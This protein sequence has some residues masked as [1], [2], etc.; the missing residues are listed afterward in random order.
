M[1]RVTGL[2]GIFF[3]CT[4][5]KKTA[6]WYQRHLGIRT[7]DGGGG[8]FEWKG[9]GTKRMAHTVWGPFPANTKYFRPSKKQFMLNYR[10]DNLKRLLKQLKK[11]GVKVVGDIEEYD[12]G[13]FGWIVDPDGNKIELWEPNDKVFR[14]LNKLVP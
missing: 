4:N 6:D 1:K 5:P 13:K 2:G 7:V 11:E 14:K 8:I 3:K 12:Y 9:K 10:V